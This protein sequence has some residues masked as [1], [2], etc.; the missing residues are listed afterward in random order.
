MDWLM[1]YATDSGIMLR[2]GCFF[3]TAQEFITRLGATHAADS[4]HA[5]E[6][7]AALD[8]IKKHLEIWA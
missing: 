5:R 4:K 3:G 1:A 8:L 2:T 7:T 6:Y